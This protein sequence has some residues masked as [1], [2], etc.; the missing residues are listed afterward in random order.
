LVPIAA[1][2]AGIAVVTVTGAGAASTTANFAAKKKP[3][4]PANCVNVRYH[5]RGGRQ[6]IVCK[7]PVGARGKLGSAGIK[8]P[9]GQ[10]GVPG[11]SAAGPV[12]VPRTT[13]PFTSGFQ[14]EGGNVQNLVTVGPIHIDGLCRKTFSP[15]TGG[16]GA[17]GEFDSQ[18]SSNPRYPAPFLPSIGGET[19][20]KIVV[21]SENGS[22]TFKG[23]A[24]P[25]INIPSGPPAYANDDTLRTTGSV[26][27]VAGEG[28]HMFVGASNERA[29]ETRAT[30][31]QVQDQSNVGSA[32]QLNRYPA[33][34]TGSGP[35]AT[36]T[37]HVLFAT[38]LAGFDT[39]GIY[40][41]CVFSGVVHSL[42]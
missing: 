20:A 31:P 10:A 8:G 13:I 21:W 32:R 18:S 22:L 6:V 1:L 42:S 15:G 16:G 24:G 36:N 17:T 33:F 38:F 34:N 9:P 30:D 28:D 5:P 35:I 37:G 3:R 14:V 19:E 23:Q 29:N 39:F 41:Q 27:P 26:D 4:L 25:R 7:G 12:V 40:D 2:A 11:S